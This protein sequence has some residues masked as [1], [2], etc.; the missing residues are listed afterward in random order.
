MSARDTL[1]P[2]LRAEV[3]R[4]E[5]DLRAR[6]ASIQDVQDAW[7]AEYDAARAAERTAAAWE[8]WVDERVT[9][10]AVAWVLTTVFVRF[11][12]DNALV[13][14][15]WISGPRHREAVDAQQQ[16]L[17]ETARAKADVTDREWLLQSVD[18]LKS[19]PAT[20]GL[21]DDTSPMWLVTPSGDAATRLLNFWRERDESGALVRDLS[22]SDLDT[23]FLGDLY[24]EISEDAKKRYALLQTPVFVEEFILDRTLDP[25]LNER[26]LEG[27]KM[28]DPTCGSGH[29]LLGAFQRLLDRWHKHAPV[30]D[31]RERVQAALDSVY[32]V[33]INPFAIAI[34]RF[35]LTVAA[36]KACEMVSLE[37]APSFK[38]HLATGDSLLHGLDQSSLDLGRDLMPDK[39]AANF[40]YGTESLGALKSILRNGQYDCVVGNPP[41]ITVK[42]KAL[43]ELYRREYNYCKGKYALTVPFME[44]FYRLAK[45]GDQ[46]GWVGQITSNSFMKREFGAPLIEKFF[47]RIDLQLVADTSGAYVPG[48]GTPT[49]ILVGRNAPAARQTVRAVLGVRGEPGRP[50]DPSEGHVWREIVDRVDDPSWNGQWVTVTDASRERLATHPWSLSGG[51][52]PDVAAAIDR[53]AGALLG[54]RI[55]EA[56]FSDIPGDDEVFVMSRTAAARLGLTEVA[57]I[58]FGDDVRDHSITTRAVALFPTSWSGEPIEL[59]DRAL[60][61]LWNFRTGLASRLYFGK[62]PAERGLRW[63]DH[64][65]FQPDKHANGFL[66][67]YPNVATHNH[68]VLGRPGTLFSMPAPVL[69]LPAGATEADHLRLLGILNSSVA[70]FWI[71]Q[72]AHDKGNGG[73]GGGIADQAWERFVQLNGTR[74]KKFPLPPGDAGDRPGLLDQLAS[75]LADNTPAALAARGEFS[76][77]ALDAARAKHESLRGRLIAAQEELDWAVYRLYGLIEEDLT[78]RGGDLVELSL[79]QR[80]FEMALARRVAAGVEETSWFDRHGSTPIVDVPSEWPREYRELVL[81]RLEFA[82]SHPHIRILETPEHKRRWSADPWEKQ[83]ERALRGWLL[84]RLEAP[85]YWFDQHGRPTARS[86]ASLAD[87]VARDTVLVDVLAL[88]EGRRDVHVVTSLQRLLGSEAVPYLAA[89]RYKDSGLRKRQSWEQ[90]WELQRR[91]DAGDYDPT[92]VSLG[93]N[94]PIPVPPRYGDKDFVKKE[95]WANRGKLDVAKERFVLYPGAEREADPTPVLGW[96]GWDHAQQSLA[97]ATL[98][99]AGE[100]Q[101]WSDERL[102]PLVAGLSELL[103]W[104]EQWNTDPDPLYGGSSPADF[105]SGLMDNYMAKLGTTRESLAAWRPPAA[106]RGRKAKS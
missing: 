47:P 25:A 102:T 17:R 37:D 85:R 22:D 10:A 59:G 5:D 14:P 67:V 24:Q 28:I 52:A 36:L 38:Y 76:R 82:E 80:A 7:R 15:V 45:G 97:L 2:E 77:A 43:N 33:D 75:E 8:A 13:K 11:C 105:F 19:L 103:P 20:A 81:R 89:M 83:E 18:Y 60:K 101:G 87:D 46:A 42:D 55:A 86:V 6:V 64:A 88:W 48:H 44:R 98:I 96:A 106:R 104:V 27:F 84:D 16:F 12:E 63:F 54:D 34:A 29:F 57:D 99:Q 49:V 68:F 23:R 4:L 56:G 94:G 26:P 50:E 9:L 40:T 92:P 69:K 1:T 51:G 41:Y 78:F 70:L 32:G 100:H 31:E 39:V 90:A 74:L 66:I 53:A 65:I 95:Y 71:R 35:R 58:A 30:M 91:Q 79:G 93:G 61:Y 72:N 21:V 62:T 73:Y 3:L